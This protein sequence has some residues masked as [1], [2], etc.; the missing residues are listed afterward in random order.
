[1]G[2]VLK[3]PI[4]GAKNRDHSGGHVC[5]AVLHAIKIRLRQAVKVKT[6]NDAKFIRGKHS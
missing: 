2:A 4:I 1:V 6:A 5:P 3:F